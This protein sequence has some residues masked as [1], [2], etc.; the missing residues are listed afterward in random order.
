ML[1]RPP[2][3]AAAPAAPA[4][5]PRSHSGLRVRSRLPAAAGRGH[6]L[7][8][9]R[10]GW[11]DLTTDVDFTELAAAGEAHGLVTTFFGPQTALQRILHPTDGSAHA[12]EAPLPP[13]PPVT[14][15]KPPLRRGVCEAF[16]ALGSFVMLVQSTA[17]VADRW[18][19]RV[20][21]QPLYGPGHASIG[22]MALHH[23]LRSL[24]RIALERALALQRAHPQRRAPDERDLAAALADGLVTVV[25]C[26]KPHWRVLAAEARR[27]VEEEAEGRAAAEHTKG[28]E[29]AEAAGATLPPLYRVVAEQM[30]EDLRLLKEK[31]GV[32]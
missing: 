13:P 3:A 18:A 22:A 16:Y 15:A 17:S 32:P 2:P 27:L 5:P 4:A 30:R 21:P 10:P 12:G 26:F 31:V 14:D 7:A 9:T 25:P 23:T 28:R 20:A 11:S 19:W 29:E 6:T 8:L 1:P 24:G